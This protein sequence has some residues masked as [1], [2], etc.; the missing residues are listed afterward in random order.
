MDFD[1]EG[2]E[3]EQVGRVSRSRSITRADVIRTFRDSFEQIGGQ[4]RLALWAD[5]NPS[6]FYKLFGRMLPASSSTELDGPQEIVVRHAIAPPP[7]RPTPT[8]T[9]IA[10]VPDVDP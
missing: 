9:L 5:S 10:P 2:T 8:L 4:S 7:P 3:L 6:E 1:K